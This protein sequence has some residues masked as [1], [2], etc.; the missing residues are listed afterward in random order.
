MHKKTAAV[1]Q[2]HAGCLRTIGA[3]NV[4]LRDLRTTKKAAL[5]CDLGLLGQAEEVLSGG[6]MRVEPPSPGTAEDDDEYPRR[7][8]VWERVR[9][10]ARKAAVEG[11]NKEVTYGAP[12][13]VG[14]LPRAKKLE[15]VLAPLLMQAVEVAV[16]EDGAIEIRSKDE[17]PRFN[18]VVWSDAFSSGDVDQIVS[19][20]IDAQADL[21]ERYD[22]DRVRTL[23]NA[24]ATVFPGLKPETPEGVLDPWPPRP[25]PSEFKDVTPYLRLLEG[26]GIYLSNRASP[27]LL[28][29][30]E[31]IA[32]SPDPLLKSDHPLSILVSKPSSQSQPELRSPDID[33][34]EFPFPSNDAQRRVGDAVDKN[35]V[36]VVQGPPGNGKSL[37]IANLACHLVAQGKSVLVTSHKDQALTVV[38]DKLEETNLQFLYATL[39][40]GTGAAKRELQGQIQDVKAFAGAVNAD[41]LRRQL[42]AVEEHRKVS[43]ERY[44]E[45]RDDFN[46]RAEAEQQEAADLQLQLEPVATLPPEDPVVTDTDT[47]AR[48]IRRLDELARRHAHSW[49]WLRNASVASKTDVADE[50][51]A[52]A[53][54]I[55]L[56]QARLRAARDPDVRSIVEAW[57]P[58]ADER[59]ESVSGCE[60]CLDEIEGALGPPLA[61][62][63]QHP[64][65][66]QLD[67]AGNSLASTP[68]LLEDVKRHVSAMQEQF[69]RAREVSDARQDVRADPGRRAE[70][71]AQH[72][73]AQQMLKRRAARRWLETN[74]PG[75]AG[76]D[77][78]SVERWRDFWE[79]WTSIRTIA[80][81]LPAGLRMEIP[82]QFDPDQVA[83]LIARTQTATQLA[84]GIR[85]SVQASQRSPL[86]LDFQA[87]GSITLPEFMEEI[88]DRRLALTSLDAD[89]VGNTAKVAKTLSFAGDR[90]PNLDRLIDDKNY[91]AAD[92]AITELTEVLAALP[93]IAE[94]RQL[95]NGPLGQLDKTTSEVERAA[96]EGKESPPFLSDPERALD[97]HPSV[98]RLEE[99]RSG[100]ST[101]TLA[102]QLRELRA[103]V[104]EDT[105]KLLGLRIQDRIV[106]GFRSPRFLASLEAFRKAIRASA[107]RFERIEA[108]KN[109]D[110][111]DVGILTQVF[112]CWIMRPEEACRVFPLAADL[113]DVVI[114]DEASQC[115]PDQALPLFAR[116][117]RVAVFGDEKQ[118]S[119]EDLRR[120]LSGPNNQALL[121]Q[122]ELDAIDPEGL[123]DQTRNSLLDL[124]EQR[125]QA[126]VVLNEHFRCRPEIIA[127]S[128]D[129]FY[130]N[131][132]RVMRDRED[133]RGLGHPFI[134]REVVGVPDLGKAK[135]NPYEA[136]MVVRELEGRLDDPRYEGMSFGVLS[137]F[138]DQIEQIEELIEKQIAREKRE[139]HKVICSTVDGFQGDERDVILYSWR[140]TPT[141]SPSILSFTNGE[142]GSQR[143]NVALTRA[144]HQAIHFISAPV[145]RFPTGSRNVSGFLR[146]AKNPSFLVTHAESR[147]HHEPRDA[148]RERLASLLQEASLHVEER[149][150]AGGTS[151][152]LKVVDPET[153]GRI[154][155]FVDSKLAPDPPATVVRRV[156]A[157]G[158]L[159]RAGWKV[160]RVPA[161]EMDRP[162]NVVETVLSALGEVGPRPEADERE[163]AFG[164]V[165]CEVDPTERSAV[166]FDG[167]ID[168]EDRADYRWEPADVETRLQAGEDVF[169]SDFE[170]QLY[171]RL[172][173]KTG[174]TVIP[175]WPSRNKSIDLVLT[176]A[177]GR[178]LAI[179]ADG[180]IYH[181]TQEGDLIP[182]DLNR[183]E[184]LEAAGW[185]FHR[186]RFT[187]FKAD[188]EK[189]IGEVLDALSRQPANPLL[190][191]GA[192][193]ATPGLSG[194]SD[195]NIPNQFIASTPT[196]DDLEVSTPPVES[197][198]SIEH[199]VP[200]PEERL[201]TPTEEEVGQREEDR[202]GAISDPPSLDDLPLDEVPRRVVTIVGRVR[203]LSDGD[204]AAAIESEIQEG[205]RRTRLINSFA[206]YA[207]AKGC[208]ERT[209]NDDGWVAVDNPPQLP[210]WCHWS[211]NQLSRRA[212][213]FMALGVVGDE[214]FERLISGIT[215]GGTHVPKPYAR[216]VGAAINKAQQD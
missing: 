9:D 67:A 127:F 20:G 87:T 113:F 190:A 174:L 179:E 193:V 26:G 64:N 165:Q 17:P 157:Q 11:H 154:A 208:L 36:V 106:N 47:A 148:M 136:E 206:W 21:A 81:G 181:E 53:E 88:E 48:S 74:A 101:Q 170:R 109:S 212:K 104:L 37:T 75:A 159:E 61:A 184:L 76:L 161:A 156:D 188:P 107:K 93:A 189:A 6:H 185:V 108:L 80:S 63:A 182:E 160:L 32:A 5:A 15:T 147:I 8:E 58:L 205:S 2:Y 33:E 200:S 150:V 92:V 95:L 215:D 192:S 35:R 102:E 66:K 77:S 180:E 23:L 171:D 175:Q 118:L 214:L 105:R 191:A 117:K 10:L 100:E 153:R 24:I 120:S 82:E 139:R 149:F 22:P 197:D 40:G 151:I 173:V 144:R 146:H 90:V 3:Q 145:E 115:N 38:R 125:K 143:S 49:D 158:M 89:R 86:P 30:L 19:L 207:K 183:Q 98:K 60:A 122:S 198:A 129:S 169:Q 133:D 91:A 65:T 14:V 194:D 59:P 29:D 51:R 99:I 50:Q 7:L 31:R 34:V 103:T 94:R 124:V 1:A 54:F 202:H 203:E 162:W 204:L 211:I 130:G 28:A 42:A 70:V 119:N 85:A 43:G 73:A 12:L 176:D 137:L 201:E 45:L 178:R 167:E 141:C 163:P 13:L 123:F 131:S 71:I 135:V 140:F 111:F 132:L 55:E 39:I 126:T 110:E 155:I 79:C 83:S 114:F 210:E 41:T 62:V 134:I 213:E 52:L 199:A 187:H 16:E 166:D 56:Q 116:A 69:A 186:I 168:L 209:A 46:N 96:L 72:N 172:A 152:D 142:A 68:D 121:R 195:P 57:H 44:R 78:A 4:G 177:D 25:S 164:Q 112:A 196:L 216:A 128:N 84:E 18:T 138:R 97:L 27:Y